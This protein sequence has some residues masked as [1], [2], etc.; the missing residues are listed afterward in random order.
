[1]GVLTSSVM[2]E[3]YLQYLE[4]TFIIVLRKNKI[5]FF[6]YVDDILLVHNLTYA[7]I[8]KVLCEFNNICPDVDSRWKWNKITSLAF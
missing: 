2:S 3:S 8:N 4:R 6:G 7:N 5:G 1:M